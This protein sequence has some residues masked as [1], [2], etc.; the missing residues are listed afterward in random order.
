MADAIRTVDGPLVSTYGLRPEAVT[1]DPAAELL[2]P[3]WIAARSALREV[4]EA[5]TIRHLVDR[6]LPESVQAHTRDEEAWRPH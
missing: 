5:V 6:S 4:F 3:V 1:Y 2:Q